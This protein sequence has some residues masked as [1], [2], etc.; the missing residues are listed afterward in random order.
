MGVLGVKA[1][2]VDLVD[3]LQAND[4]RAGPDMP[5]LTPPAVWVTV[6][7]VQPELLSGG[8]TVQLQLYVLA[9]NAQPLDV[10]DVLDDH[11]QQLLQLVDSDGDIVPATVATPDSRTTLPAYRV[12]VLVPYTP[13]GEATP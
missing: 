9:P 6:G 7:A 8:G 1:A 4:M 10:L 13:T 2:V 5:Q 11:T 3:H 12:T